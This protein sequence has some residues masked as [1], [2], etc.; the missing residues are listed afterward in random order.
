MKNRILL[1][2]LIGALGSQVLQ[3]QP[4]LRP[5]HHFIPTGIST[6][7]FGPN[8]FPVPDFFPG[9]PA[10]HLRIEAAGDFFKGF[11]ADGTDYTWNPYLFIEI[12]LFTHRAS[13]SVW[14]DTHEFYHFSDAVAE[15]R[16]VMETGPITGS[17]SG[18]I[19]VG[20]NILVL[21]EKG[22]WIPDIMLRAVMKTAS[23]D[24]FGRARHYDCPGYYFDAVVSKS[25]LF[26][27]GNFFRSVRASL[28]LGF[29]CW[30]T[31][32]GRQNDAF[33]V[34]LVASVDTRPVRLTAQWGGY[35]GWEKRGDHPRSVK[36]RLDIHAGRHFDVF[37]Y[38]QQGLR[39]W[40]FTQYRAGLTYYL[41]RNARP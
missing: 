10:E 21:E 22:W 35:S 7:Y 39:D 11:I 29:V 17:D 5:V 1:V 40:P 28:D 27:E 38:F 25:Y 37:F 20:T 18:D 4:E 15:A 33:M 19:Y 9:R 24:D 34:G 41:Q 8:A 2:L 32:N 12:P 6:A 31:D 30:Q 3:A 13:L 14:T 16:Q 23:G 36:A 26:P